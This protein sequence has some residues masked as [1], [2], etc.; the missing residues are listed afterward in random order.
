M[1]WALLLSDYLAI[2]APCFL[3]GH[4]CEV[5]FQPDPDEGSGSE[6]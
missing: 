2:G 5:P 4:E 6:T 1:L 3:V